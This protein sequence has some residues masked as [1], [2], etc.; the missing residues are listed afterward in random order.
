M[1]HALN[2]ESCAPP[3]AELSMP[4]KHFYARAF[5]DH[6]TSRKVGIVVYESTETGVLNR[7]EIDKILQGE[8]LDVS[9]LIRHL[10]VL[11]SEFNPSPEEE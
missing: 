1:Q 11:H 3:S 4:S 9:R 7:G 2:K 10:G 6:E 5:T 8:A